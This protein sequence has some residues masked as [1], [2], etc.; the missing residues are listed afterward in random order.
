MPILTDIE[1]LN[2]TIAGG[3]YALD[4]ILGRGGNKPI[5]ELRHTEPPAY[6]NFV[7]P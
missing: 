2:T 6:G 3:K 7:M 5:P 1:R 4:R